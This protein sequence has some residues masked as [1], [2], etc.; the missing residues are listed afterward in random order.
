MLAVVV[1]VDL[2]G[3]GGVTVLTHQN[4]PALGPG[5]KGVVEAVD[6][7]GAGVTMLTV[8]ISK[9]LGRL[10]YNVTKKLIQSRGLPYLMKNNP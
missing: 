5:V 8:I 1:V 2:V 6:A 3:R 4:L 7:V 9:L 10:Y